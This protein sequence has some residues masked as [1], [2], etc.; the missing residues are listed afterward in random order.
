MPTGD[1]IST[2]RVAHRSA[3]DVEPRT[4]LAVLDRLV[5][6]GWGPEADAASDAAW[7]A[8]LTDS[9]L[10]AE[11]ARRDLAWATARATPSAA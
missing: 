4:A 7:I 11:T 1:I 6:G 2:A 3:A 5:A 9:P 10:W 8:C